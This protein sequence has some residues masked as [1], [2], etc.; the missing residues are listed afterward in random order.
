MKNNS[1]KGGGGGG[2][3]V[4]RERHAKGGRELARSPPPPPPPPP[5]TAAASVTQKEGESLRARTAQCLHCSIVD[6][7]G[8]LA[9]ILPKEIEGL[10]AELD[11]VL[12]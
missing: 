2:G 6:T 1:F 5:Q 11:L 7:S 9:R 4:S 10:W 3:E 8:K 12:L